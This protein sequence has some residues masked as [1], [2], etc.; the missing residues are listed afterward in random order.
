MTVTLPQSPLPVFEPGSTAD[1]VWPDR[2]G[3]P[4][5]VYRDEAQFLVEFDLPGVDAD[6]IEVS[7]QGEVL[8]VRA[9]RRQPDTAGECLVA[10]RPWGVY[11]RRL[12]LDRDLDTERVH[13]SLREGVLRLRIPVRE[14]V[15]GRRVPITVG[16]GEQAARGDAAGS[17]GEG[18]AERG[19]LGRRLAGL[20]REAAKKL[21]SNRVAAAAGADSPHRCQ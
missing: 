18:A 15:T 8:A 17:A 21:V 3:M 5:H 7:V 13:A 10:E 1:G 9:Q 11:H 6:G 2:A 14:Q 20:G 4:M 19:R 16:D 12:L